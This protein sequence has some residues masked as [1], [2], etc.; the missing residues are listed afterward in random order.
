MSEILNDI[1][2]KCT[3]ANNP[4]IFILTADSLQRQYFESESR[5]L[6]RAVG[7]VE[8]T[9]AIATACRT[10]AAMPG[11]AASVFK[12]QLST[13]G[14]PS[15]GEPIPLAEALKA[16]GYTNSLWTDNYLFGEHYNYDR[17]F[18]AGAH[19]VP[20]WPTRLAN[21]IRK[22]SF[23]P[24]MELLEW[25]W[26]NVVKEITEIAGKN[27]P[28]FRRACELNEEALQ[29]LS[30]TSE[31]YF[32]WIHYMD[33]HHPYEPSAAYREELDFTVNRSASELK[34]LTRDVAK[35]NGNGFNKEEIDDVVTAYRGSCRQ[36]GDDIHQFLSDIIDRGYFDPDR[37][38]FVFTADHG[39]CLSPAK[40]DM[41]GHVPDAFWDEVVHVPLVMNVPGWESGVIE[42]QVSLLD[43]M[44]TVINA[45]GGTIPSSAKGTPAIV[46]QDMVCD[47]AFSVAQHHAEGDTLHTYRSIRTNDGWKLFGARRRDEDRVILTR[48]HDE[49]EEVI[50]NA[51]RDDQVEDI[52]MRDKWIELHNRLDSIGGVITIGETSFEEANIDTEHLEDLGYLE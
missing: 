11:L 25:G 52:P 29:W 40:T 13:W 16:E 18:T 51:H 48:I 42:E 21:W 4:N 5:T 24:A 41:F 39:E 38:I 23:A 34:R 28:F 14:I 30:T 10:S 17:G 37:D 7:G 47:D 36:F 44:P 35:S 3:M 2:V 22:S 50:Y 26:F 8:F 49:A 45:A 32:I 33:T 31:P 15:S 27:N 46:P 19:G 9:E 1:T 6:S 12:D 43:V 20:G